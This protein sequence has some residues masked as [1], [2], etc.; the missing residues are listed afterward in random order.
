V[1]DLRAKP[2]ERSELRLVS[3]SLERSSIS[4]QCVT[5]IKQMPVLQLGH[6]VWL[7]LVLSE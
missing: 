2:C 7:G 6:H 5:N 3:S 1:R 4:C